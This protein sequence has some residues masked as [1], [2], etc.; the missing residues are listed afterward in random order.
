M[1]KQRSVYSCIILAWGLCKKAPE[2]ALRIINL[3]R[4]RTAGVPILTPQRTGI[5][6]EDLLAAHAVFWLV[7]FASFPAAAFALIDD[8]WVALR[9]SNAILL[10]LF[11]V[12]GYL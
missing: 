12:I 7:V 6:G 11:F 8:P 1:V 3:A 10:A 4:R 2:E 5:R 9:M